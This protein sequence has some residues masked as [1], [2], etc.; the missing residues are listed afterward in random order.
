MSGHIAGDT[1]QILPFATSQSENNRGDLDTPFM[2]CYIRTNPGEDAM[3]HVLRLIMVS[4]WLMV[5]AS[6]AWGK[7]WY[8]DAGN[9]PGGDGSSW[10]LAFTRIQSAVDAASND[11]GGEVW[12]ARGVYFEV[13]LNGNQSLQMRTGVDLYGGFAGTESVRNA[14]NTNPVTNGTIIRGTSHTGEYNP[15]TPVV[16]GTD[17]ATL[18]GFTIAGGRTAM[19]AGMYNNAVSPRVANCVFENNLALAVTSTQGAGGGMLN[20]NGALPDVT[21]C[22]F[23]N[24]TA[25]VSGGGVA[26]LQASGGHFTRCT[27]SSNVSNQGGAIY[28]NGSSPM[29]DACI[30][31]NNMAITRYIEGSDNLQGFGG[32]GLLHWTSSRPVRGR[33][34][35]SRGQPD[36]PELPDGSE[37][38]RRFWRRC[39]Q[40]GKPGAVRALH[41]LAEFGQR[42]RQF[43]QLRRREDTVA[44]YHCLRLGNRPRRGR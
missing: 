29:F 23:R 14:R 35:L 20:I 37:L 10:A 15:R 43:L 31:S 30:V 36:L 7:V 41:C 4:L 34:G 2:L 13:V 24:N 25:D 32:G 6:T 42:G 21:D 3:Q 8:V 28:I 11:G 19:G 22:I 12:V 44:E 27:F 26:C 18:D 40:W 17:N 16:K 9:S 38:H 39:F 33:T 5:A 1:I